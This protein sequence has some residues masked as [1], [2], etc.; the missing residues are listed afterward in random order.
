MALQNKLS[1]K[2]FLPKLNEE[3]RR[4]KILTLLNAGF[5][6]RKICNQVK[7]CERTVYYVKKTGII[8]RKQRSDSTEKQNH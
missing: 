2:M 7:C 6:V 3:G 4:T 8:E 5:S 1:K